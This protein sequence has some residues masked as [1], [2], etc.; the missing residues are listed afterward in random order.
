[1]NPRTIKKMN[2]IN[3]R[4]SDHGQLARITNMSAE[5]LTLNNGMIYTGLAASRFV[6]RVMNKKVLDWV[7][8]TDNLLD[9]VITESQIKG[10][11]LSM[12]G[13]ACQQKHKEKIRKNLNSGEPWNKGKT[14]VQTGWSKGL[15]KDTDPRVA[16]LAKFGDKNGMFGTKMSDEQK[17]NHSKI[18]KE[19]ILSGRFTPN[20]NNRNTHWD[21]E[22]SSKKFRSSWEAWYQSLNP[23]SEYETLR[24][25]YKI[26]GQEKVYI[27]DFINHSNRT[28]VEVKPKELTTSKAFLSKWEA[29]VLWGEENRYTPILVTK[30][31]LIDNTQSIDYSLF[32]KKT[33]EKIKRIYET[34]KKS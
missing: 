34:S 17:N 13:K 24:I 7:K 33:S 25:L 26:D 32:D 14:G 3:Q 1:M 27:V 5:S 31:W 12:R 19:S 18:M 2:S 20:S 16:K 8:N 29:L 6:K 10:I 22:F 28:V 15:T 11:S 9:G 30:Q 4:L 23:E 21:A